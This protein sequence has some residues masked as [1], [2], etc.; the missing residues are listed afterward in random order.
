VL[1]TV[2]GNQKILHRQ[3]RSQFQGKRKIP[4]TATDYEKRHGRDTTW[5]LRPKE[6][7]HCQATSAFGPPATRKLA[8]L[9]AWWWAPCGV[10]WSWASS[11]FSVVVLVARHPGS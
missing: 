2:R 6:A 3:I 8:H 4:F 7:P 11:L 5:T 10:A 9:G 1:L